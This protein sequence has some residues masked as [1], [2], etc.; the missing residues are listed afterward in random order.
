MQESVT[1]LHAALP[2]GADFVLHAAG[3]LEAALTIGYERIVLDADH[4]GA[5]HALLGGLAVDSGTLALTEHSGRLQR[6]PPP[7][8]S[9]CVQ[10]IKDL[11][12][13][14]LQPFECQAVQNLT[15][16]EQ[17]PIGIGQTRLVADGSSG[18]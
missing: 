16:P 14:Y 6:R 8:P 17:P 2:C 9:T 13:P 10:T 11:A 15:P 1:S 4:P 12:E 18:R 5:V 7:S 3:R